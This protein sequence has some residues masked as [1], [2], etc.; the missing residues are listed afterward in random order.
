MQIK[1]IKQIK[2]LIDFTKE[3]SRGP[4][5]KLP[6]DTKNKYYSFTLLN[7][8]D[9]TSANQNEYESE[10]VTNIQWSSSIDNNI[11]IVKDILSESKQ[12]NLKNS[13]GVAEKRMKRS[14]E[15]MKAIIG[16]VNTNY[17]FLWSCLTHFAK[18]TRNSF[19]SLFYTV[20]STYDTEKSQNLLAYAHVQDAL[21]TFT[22]V[23]NQCESGNGRTLIG[24]MFTNVKRTWEIENE[25]H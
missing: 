5:L 3:N 7:E 13:D 22:V 2:A 18:S 25:N 15:G 6:K 8:Y 24:E 11:S 23:N 12:F 1:K 10:G 16:S 14:I 19:L 21:S 17:S 20:N 9:K 4:F